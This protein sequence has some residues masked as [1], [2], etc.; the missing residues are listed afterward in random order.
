MMGGPT[1]GCGV[2]K[3]R[4]GPY[5]RASTRVSGQW[6]GIGLIPRDRVEWPHIFV[7]NVIIFMQMYLLLVDM[8]S[9]SRIF[10][11]FVIILLCVHVLYIIITVPPE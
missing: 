9:S 5:M 6:K 1:N 2:P 4:A 11:S 8:C 3:P 7:V 10:Y